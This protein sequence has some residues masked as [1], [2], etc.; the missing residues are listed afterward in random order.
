MTR[1]STAVDIRQLRYFVV[2]AEQ[3]SFR[4]AADYM[5]VQASSVSRGIRDLEDE[6]GA[7]LFQRCCSGVTLTEAGK[8]FLEGATQV[9]AIIEREAQQ[10]SR[11]GRGEKGRIRIGVFASLSSQF[12]ND[13]IETYATLYEDVELEFI[14]GVPERHVA[15]IRQGSLDVAFLPGTNDWV[16]CAC[17]HLW[18]ERMF[19]VLPVDHPLRRKRQVSWHDL[20][21]EI[22]L[23]NEI[24]PWTMFEKHVVRRF[25]ELGYQPNVRLH[26]VD[27]ENLLPLVALGHGLCVTPESVTRLRRPRLIYRPICQEIIAF[28]AV[29]SPRNDNPALRRLLSL[30][31]A[32][33]V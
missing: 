30:S 29:W 13:L 11:V 31:R 24:G 5:R 2:A 19:V 12:L 25:V 15:G 32:K 3:C 17:V 18:S 14:D 1:I 23:V 21:S 26:S 7:S 28:R 16:E 33:A 27:R 10:V 22:F 4:K 9:L 6:I 8:S 20:K